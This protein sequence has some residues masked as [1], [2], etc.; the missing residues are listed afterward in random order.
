MGKNINLLY[1]I[2]GSAVLALLNN[3][4]FSY[5]K[6]GIFKNGYGG[7]I[8]GEILVKVTN[9][10]SLFGFILLM[11]FSVILIGRNINFRNN[12]L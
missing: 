12:G 9:I 7:N 6:L 8:F 3:P 4:I 2:V 10:L 1:C 5:S 11:I